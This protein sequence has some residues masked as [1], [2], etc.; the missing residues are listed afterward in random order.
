MDQ[1]EKQAAFGRV[2]GRL[3]GNME[4][5]L[6][7]GIPVGILID[8]SVVTK[9][10]QLVSLLQH[11]QERDPTVPERREA[12][13]EIPEYRA[14]G[15]VEHVRSW[16]T[17]VSWKGRRGR[18]DIWAHWKTKHVV[19]VFTPDLGEDRIYA[20]LET[21]DL[22]RR[23]GQS[24]GEKKARRDLED[25]L[26]D[27]QRREL[28]LSD[29]FWEVGKSGVSYLVRRNRPTVA[30]RRN[31]ERLKVI[32]ALCMH[33]LLYYAGTWSGGLPPSDEMIS[34]VIFIR[35]DEYRFWLKANQID[36]HE[37]NAGL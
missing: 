20:T 18:V 34:V 23:Y 14:R 28:L 9:H 32:C 1:L 3:F 22:L 16:N 5:V 37:W 33:P 24:D 6:P 36:V 30:C 4:E 26:S 21:T 8:R 2:L 7:C 17:K 12:R 13:G 19:K 27:D 31:G 29:A 35:A 11:M 10:P 15:Y 25:V